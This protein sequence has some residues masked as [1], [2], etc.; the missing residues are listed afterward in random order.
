MHAFLRFMNN[1][2]NLH[3]NPHIR[4]FRRRVNF[5]NLNFNYYLLA[6]IMK[7]KDFRIYNKNIKAHFMIFPII[8][9]PYGDL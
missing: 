6:I 8:M 9:I 4:N 5:G 7:D 2:L 1:T 3:E